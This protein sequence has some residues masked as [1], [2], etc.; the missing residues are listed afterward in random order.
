MGSLIQTAKK[1]TSLSGNMD[2]YLE[3]RIKENW[4]DLI[5]QDFI[6]EEGR[7]RNLFSKHQEQAR[8][9]LL[10][11]LASK[12]LSNYL[13]FQ[14]SRKWVIQRVCWRARENRSGQAGFLGCDYYSNLKCKACLL[15]KYH[16]APRWTCSWSTSKKML[17]IISTGTLR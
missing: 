2:F 13:H 8:N 10:I 17:T 5:F 6:K 16:L 9:L 1:N 15:P 3:L 11:L 14:R 12:Y 4:L 7:K